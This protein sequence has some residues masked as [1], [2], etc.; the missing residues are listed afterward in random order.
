MSGS[1]EDAVPTCIAG[2]MSVK[3]ECG[4]EMVFIQPE[5]HLAVLNYVFEHLKQVHQVVFPTICCYWH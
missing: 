5:E 2:A 1:V 3:C 4:W